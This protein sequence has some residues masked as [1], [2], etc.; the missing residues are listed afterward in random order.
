MVALD[1][2]REGF[3]FVF[4]NAVSDQSVAIKNTNNTSDAY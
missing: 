3:L 2:G 1:E 4:V